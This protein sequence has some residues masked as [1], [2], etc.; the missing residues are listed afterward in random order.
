MNLRE[1]V[2]VHVVQ[3]GILCVKLDAVA[4]VILGVRAH[5]V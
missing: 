4:H 2:Y 1:K 3:N 5:V